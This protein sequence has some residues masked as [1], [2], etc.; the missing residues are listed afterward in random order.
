MRKNGVHELATATI[1]FAITAL[2]FISMFSQGA[3]AEQLKEE[4][5][6]TKLEAFTGTVGVVSIKGYVE[7]GTMSSFTNPIKVIAM[8]IRDAKTE[9]QT[10]GAVFEIA[11][12]KSYGV[13][14]RQSY[15]DADELADLLSGLTYISKA[16]DTSTPMRFYEAQYSTRGGLK[17]IVF[18]NATGQRQFSVHVGGAIGGQDA[19][20]AIQDLPKFWDL[21][22]KAKETIE[23]PE[24]LG[25]G[26]SATSPA[27]A[28][29]TPPSPIQPTRNH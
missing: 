23:N 10:S 24:R 17:L 3:E 1:L 16:D 9:T 29:P 7:V 14:R 2:T 27:S 18:N 12:T 26:F 28:S 6:K 5:A 21:I 22:A 11:E 19:Y 15:V 20:F 25:K 4:A 8:T 13:D